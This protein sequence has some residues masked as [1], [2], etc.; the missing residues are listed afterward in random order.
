MEVIV[1]TG[2]P[3]NVWFE[4]GFNASAPTYGLPPA[5]VP[6]ES[7]SHPNHFYTLQSYTSSNA[8]LL[9]PRGKGVLDIKS[10]KAAEGLSFLGASAFGQASV[11]YKIYYEDQ[12]SQTGTLLLPD[13]FNGAAPAF[14]ANGRFNM[15][16]RDFDSAAGQNPRLY[17]RDVSLTNTT[18]PVTRIE[19][20]NTEMAFRNTAI[21][22][23]SGGSTGES[24]FTPV[25]INGF[26][27]DIVIEAD[28]Q[29]FRAPDWQVGAPM[30]P[31][32]G[33]VGG[34]TIRIEAMVRNL[35]QVAAPPTQARL[36]ISPEGPIGAAPIWEEIKDVPA[37]PPGGSSTIAFEYQLPS[38][39][40]TNLLEVRITVDAEDT[41]AEFTGKNNVGLRSQIRIGPNLDLWF[42]KADVVTTNNSR[43]LEVRF[44][45]QNGGSESPP[46]TAKIY[47][48]KDLPA[49]SE[50]HLIAEV[51]VP[52]ITANSDSPT[53][54]V[55]HPIPADVPEGFYSLIIF[56]DPSNLVPEYLEGAFNWF[57]V[58]VPARNPG[59]LLVTYNREA[60]GLTISATPPSPAVLETSAD[61][62]T[63]E[64]VT[65]VN[66]GELFSRSVPAATSRG[67]FRLRP[68][69]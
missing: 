68:S 31:S 38:S 56:L 63:W 17:A 36:R 1:G 66:A 9:A 65:S 18:S 32:S 44:A 39:S 2:N 26:N 4:R 29:G 28:Y 25:D 14:V 16:T 42:Q 67:F 57:N 13:W 59:A 60:N 30:H 53:I 48:G 7:A 3:M 34:E 22:A 47:F 10:P 5:G 40:A 62:M 11:S 41:V 54:V 35:S 23:V 15:A 37:L 6:F 46:T 61:L 52:G 49:P 27:H 33:F 58:A 69:P 43:V 20:Q 55:R 8:L 24:M 51:P 21:L 19:L 12:T 50:A 64:S 45:V